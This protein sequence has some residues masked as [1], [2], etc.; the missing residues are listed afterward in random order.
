MNLRPRLLIS[1]GLTLICLFV[2]LT[3]VTRAALL[4]KFAVLE[5][6]MTLTSLKRLRQTVQQLVYEQHVRVGDW[7]NRDD[8]RQF[9]ANSN[10]QFLRDH[11]TP[12]M[13]KHSGFDVIEFVSP[14]GKILS[15]RS[16]P[17]DGFLAS[18]DAQELLRQ[19]RGRLEYP[20]AKA[21][22]ISGMVLYHEAPLMVSIRPVHME[23]EGGPLRG[24]V[25][26]GSYFDKDALARV[27]KMTELD[28]RALPAPVAGSQTHLATLGNDFVAPVNSNIVEGYTVM[29]DLEGK[30]ALYL[31]L[32][33]PR[34]IYSQGL[35]AE[36]FVSLVLILAG[37]IL[38][39]VIVFVLEKSALSRVSSLTRQVEEI[40]EESETARV[41][42][43]GRDELSVLASRI[44]RM[45]GRLARARKE[46]EHQAFH[47]KL[48]D[49][50][51]RALFMDRIELA[52]AK[53][54]RNA[55]GTAVLFIDLDNF[56]LVNDSLGHDAGDTLL[57][58]VG[59]RL[60]ASVRPGD[61]VARLGGDEF[62]ILLEDLA[63]IEEAEVIAVRVQD[64]LLAPVKIGG[65]DAFVSAS[66]GISLTNDRSTTPEELMKNADTA[67]YHAKAK[68]K[69][70]YAIYDVCMQD[71][72]TERMELETSLRRALKS[73]EISVE[74]QP[75]ID[76]K[77]GEINGA[78]ALARWKH[79]HRGMVPPSQ[80]IPIAEDTGL[81][82]TIGYFVLEESCR[83]AVEWQK[84]LADEDFTIS[85]NLSGR[86]LQQPDVVDT[87]A[88]VLERTGLEPRCLKLEIT[89]S[90][91][92]EG[93][94]NI[95]KLR[96]LKVLGL[97]L[98]LDDFGT[99][100][101]SLASLSAFPIDTI[102]IDRTFISRLG[103]DE[104]ARA[105]VGA[106]MALSR[107]MKMDVTSEG[108]ETDLQL[109]MISSLG[110][111][112]G[113]GYLFD[114]PLNAEAFATKLGALKR[115]AA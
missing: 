31:A 20:Q 9:M 112:T 5:R 81:I 71:A 105:V 43:G 28:A 101:S 83:Q 93:P 29:S 53:A 51:N 62:T 79:P 34:T 3:F 110:C 103:E 86:Q 17:A 95:E 15:A 76:L 104:P 85:V 111:E 24:W 75:L 89:E 96:S 10:P 52:F 97:K 49:L 69:S 59:R 14:D 74:Y 99:G 2:G 87:I 109:E 107:S 60:Q 40:D 48:S 73:G 44:N 30:S 26:V 63:S 57:I 61:T 16:G 54:T 78:E 114:R 80:F 58:E 21:D 94:E 25:I 27:Q 6:E 46:A 42:I 36:Q 102:K 37:L 100:Y 4:Q 56:K 23:D 50:P 22:G 92:M 91:L 77:T 68:G 11:V 41:R 98:A 72:V 113:Q 90:V 108:V 12:K 33:E 47:D 8:T 32:K 1:V 88:G 84:E 39:A 18:P 55:L 45:V 66:V 19:V 64:S 13:L 70:C 65:T 38:G 82:L 35:D 7:A 115:N 67:M 106:I